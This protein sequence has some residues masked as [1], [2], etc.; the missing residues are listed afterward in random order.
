MVFNITTSGLVY[1]IA[2]VAVIAIGLSIAGMS[3]LFSMGET[4]KMQQLFTHEIVHPMEGPTKEFVDVDC[5]TEGS[6]LVMSKITL[7][8]MSFEYIGKEKAIR[9]ILLLDAG[10]T[11]IQGR[12]I[13]GTNLDDKTIG[14]KTDEDGSV[15]CDPP[16]DYYFELTGLIPANRPREYFHFTIWR[17]DVPTIESTLTKMLG[18]NDRYYLASFGIGGIVDSEMCRAFLCRQMAS[19][20]CQASNDCYWVGGFFTKKECKACPAIG[21]CKNHNEEQCKNCKSAKSGCEWFEGKCATKDY[22]SAER[23]CTACVGSSCNSEICHNKLPTTSA[24]KCWFMSANKVCRICADNPS[25]GMFD[26]D[27]C[28]TEDVQ[29]GLSCKKDINDICVNA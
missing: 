15:Q 4:K 11:L 26:K 28:E 12:Y 20:A 18:I 13:G 25:C 8:G 23:N 5:E 21:E 10:N 19:A 27:D 22:A 9:F 6:A 3:S 24:Y 7:K 1:I 14:C 2:M 29:C 17:A 16:R